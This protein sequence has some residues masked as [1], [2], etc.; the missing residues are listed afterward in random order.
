MKKRSVLRIFGVMAV[1]FVFL[2]PFLFFKNTY[3]LAPTAHVPQKAALPY[4]EISRPRQSGE[5]LVYD[6]K[7]GRISL[8]RATFTDLPEASLAGR[9]VAVATFETKVAGFY[10][11]EKIFSDTATSLPVRIE[12]FVSTWPAAEYIVEEYDQ[13]N[14]TVTITKK[15]GDRETKMVIKKG[16]V[17]N[18]AVIL[19]FFIRSTAQ[20][21]IGYSFVVRLPTREYTV[22]LVSKEEVEVPAG[23]FIA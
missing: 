7:L 19:P 5:K 8:G 10:D 21:D 2:S 20:L 4:S 23:S 11:M 3:R 15:K 17:I 12:R 14:F 6:V 18:N 13:K 1:A 22:R 9:T 16:N